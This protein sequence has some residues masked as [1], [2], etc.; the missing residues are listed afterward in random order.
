MK[1]V[2][3]SDGTIEYITEDTDYK[4]LRNV[5]DEYNN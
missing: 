5:E 4:E 2:V 1:Y 3:L